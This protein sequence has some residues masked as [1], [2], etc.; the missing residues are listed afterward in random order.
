MRRQL[1]VYSPISLEA[2]GRAVAALRD[3]A[4]ARVALTRY[5]TDTFDAE[6]VILTSSGTHALQLAL[7]RVRSLGTMGRV[8]ALPGYSCFDLVSAAVGA[9]VRVRFYDVDPKTL[10]PDLDSVRT[11]VQEGVSAV[12]AGSLYGY[13]LDWAGLRAVCESEGVDLIEDAAQGVGTLAGAKVGGALAPT[14]V[15]SFGRGKGWTGGG[16]G[17]LL[18]RDSAVEPAEHVKLMRSSWGTDAKAALVTAAAWMFGRPTLYVIPTSV[19]ALGLGETKYHSPSTP[20]VMSAFS[21]ALAART[22]AEA[23]G[24]FEGR[25]RNAD[26]WSQALEEVSDTSAVTPCRLVGGGLGS[27][28]FLR[29]ALIARD[30]G[31]AAALCGAGRAL[32]VAAGYPIALHR[33]EQ[34]QSLIC[35]SPSSLPGSERLAETLITLPTHAWVRPADVTRLTNVLAGM[36]D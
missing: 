3:R 34:A 20:R 13:P 36:R 25:R 16:G 7:E 24:A 27:A 19:P 17:A 2:I 15:I 4:G 14:T 12:V 9:G 30:G 8:V 23:Q 22:A 21:A 5:L 32:G 35:D 28:T 11:V 10:S 33:L 1:P 6:Q 18:V 31:F 29:Y 26:R